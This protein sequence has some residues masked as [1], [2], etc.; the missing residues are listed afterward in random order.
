MTSLQN[1]SCPYE[2]EHGGTYLQN[3]VQLTDIYMYTDRRTLFEKCGA[4]LGLEWHNYLQNSIIRTL[5]LTPTNTNLWE[6]S[7]FLASHK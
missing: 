6:M 4:C 7:H 3:D 5:K 1:R 2:L